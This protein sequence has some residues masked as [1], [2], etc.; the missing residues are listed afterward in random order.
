MDTDYLEASPQSRRRLVLIFVFVLVAGV[1][2]IEALKTYSDRVK[3]LPICD[4]IIT[5]HWLWTG[6]CL[7]LAV[8]GIWVGWLAQRALKSNQWP[9]PG[10]WI[11]HRTRI[12]RGNSAKWR[13]YV[14]LSWSVF[15][16]VG[17]TWSWYVL[18]NYLAR[19]QSHRC[20]ER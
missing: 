7:A 20:V 19:V 13:A 4:Q 18:E 8:L 16:L 12:Y 2:V 5:L 14:L 17:S 15:V 1:V 6:A 10:A 9:P 3:T 11:F